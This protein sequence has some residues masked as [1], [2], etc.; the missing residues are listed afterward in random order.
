MY[1]IGIKLN[2]FSFLI[3]LILRSWSGPWAWPWSGLWAG[4]WMFLPRLGSAVILL[5]GW[6]T[7]GRFNST[8]L[9]PVLH[10]GRWTTPGLLVITYLLGSAAWIPLWLYLW[11]ALWAGLGFPVGWRWVGFTGAWARFGFAGSRTRPS[12]ART[13]FTFSRLG[14]RLSS[15]SWAGMTTSLVA[16]GARPI[17]RKKGNNL[18]YLSFCMTIPI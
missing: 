18:L 17:R 9:L 2:N 8:L 3:Q 13:G 14:A 1:S 6:G 5:W 11:M 4:G 16:A 10:W 15:R 12:V 7:G